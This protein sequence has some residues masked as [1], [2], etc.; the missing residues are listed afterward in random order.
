MLILLFIMAPAPNLQHFQIEMRFERLGGS[1]SLLLKSTHSAEEQSF[2]KS[3]IF[4]YQLIFDTSAL[5]LMLIFFKLKS[6][7]A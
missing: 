3:T 5:F 6:R 1:S 2:K 4:W 7:N